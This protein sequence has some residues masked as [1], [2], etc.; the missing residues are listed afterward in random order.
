MLDQDRPKAEQ[1]DQRE[2]G[3]QASWRV[4]NG[5]HGITPKLGDNSGVMSVQVDVWRALQHLRAAQRLLRAAFA[6]DV[7][8]PLNRAI[9]V[10]EARLSRQRPAQ[11]PL[12]F[13]A[14][15]V[16]GPAV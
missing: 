8:I 3:G 12:A 14:A 6:L 16:D 5:P 9:R 2:P 15:D 10:A 13:E 1:R 7:L 11:P 4:I